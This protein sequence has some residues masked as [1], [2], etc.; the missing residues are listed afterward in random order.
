MLIPLIEPLWRKGLGTTYTQ[1]AASVWRS[2]FGTSLG[3]AVPEPASALLLLIGVLAI[4][5]RRGIT[6]S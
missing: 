3:S 4:F 6:A 1:A 5:F 2:Y